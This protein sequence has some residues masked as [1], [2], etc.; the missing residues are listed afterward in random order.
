[1]ARE[2]EEGQSQELE[3]RENKTAKRKRKRGTRRN[4]IFATTTPN[5]KIF[6][7]SH[8]KQK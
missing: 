4:I 6:S 3:R 5:I 2:Q 7:S 1:M 8:L